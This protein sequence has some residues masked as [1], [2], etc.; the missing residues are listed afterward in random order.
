MISL[1]CLAGNKNVD[2]LANHVFCLSDSDMSNLLTVVAPSVPR[3]PNLRLE[4]L[5][6]RG[7]EVTWQIPQEMGEV[8]LSVCHT[9]FTVYW[10]SH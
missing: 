7:I 4:G 1:Q 5:S 9:N 2:P 3:S 8:K 6:S 10:F